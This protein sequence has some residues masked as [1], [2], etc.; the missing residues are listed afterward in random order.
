VALCW[1]FA[2]QLALEGR[3]GARVM[4]AGAR[5]APRAAPRAD[6]L[7]VPMVALVRSG[8]EAWRCA[9][10]L[11]CRWIWRL[12]RRGAGARWV[13]RA[14]LRADGLVVPMVA[15]VRSGVEAW[16]CVGCLQCRWLWR[17]G[18]GFGYGALGQGR[19]HLRRCGRMDPSGLWLSSSAAVVH[20]RVDARGDLSRSGV[21]IPPLHPDRKYR[22]LLTG[23]EQKTA[24]GLGCLFGMVLSIAC[25]P[26]LCI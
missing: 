3:R 2:V 1:L 25:T 24:I 20:P 12:G 26:L 6:E 19:L 17:E 15:L 4:G 21:P 13:P 8:V 5:W 22:C 10:C 11:Q 16:R 14:P 9:W 23:F 18:G 7:V